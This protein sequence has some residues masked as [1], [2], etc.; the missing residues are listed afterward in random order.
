MSLS[1]GNTIS[2]YSGPLFLSTL[3]CLHPVVIDF[4]LIM[5]ALF[6]NY[7][8]FVNGAPVEPIV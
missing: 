2:G 3:P 8:I 4:H 5:L 6:L 1:N 7:E